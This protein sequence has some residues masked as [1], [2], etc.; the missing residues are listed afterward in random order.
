MPARF[1]EALSFNSP[2][3]SARMERTIMGCKLR[4]ASVNESTSS[5]HNANLTTMSKLGSNQ[6]RATSM[7]KTMRNY[8]RT[9]MDKY[10][11]G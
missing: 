9:S 5:R 6:D 4:D 7:P 11:T 2:E 8:A 1:S 10:L 3:V